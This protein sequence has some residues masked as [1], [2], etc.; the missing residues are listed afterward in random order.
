MFLLFELICLQKNKRF[1]NFAGFDHFVYLLLSLIMEWSHFVSIEV[2][3]L[4][5]IWRYFNFVT[6]CF[7][8]KK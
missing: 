2:F 6:M 1:Y 7:I 8:I 4:D 3:S 5:F